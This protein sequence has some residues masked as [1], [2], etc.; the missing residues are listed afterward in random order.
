MQQHETKNPSLLLR[1][2]C[3][4]DGITPARGFGR[5]GCPEYRTSVVRIYIVFTL[6]YDFKDFHFP[7]I[8]VRN[9]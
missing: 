2:G 4:M 7:N 3:C 9:H 1:Y 8:I 6:L 5:A